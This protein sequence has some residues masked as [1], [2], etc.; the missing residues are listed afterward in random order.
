ML[1]TEEGWSSQALS[2]RVS[3]IEQTREELCRNREGGIGDHLDHLQIRQIPTV[4]SQFPT[5]N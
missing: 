5:T 2:F 1:V 4:W 3:N